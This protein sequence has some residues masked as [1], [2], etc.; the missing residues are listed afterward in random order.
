MI[1]EI[2]IWPDHRLNE[3]SVPIPFQELVD[4]PQS[5]A[6]LTQLIQDM[7]DTMYDTG[8][9]GLAAIQIGV[10]LRVVIMDTKKPV[11]LINPVIEACFG[12]KVMKNEGCLSLPGIIERVERYE[13]IS[14]SFYD[15]DGVKH[16]SKLSGLNA[17]CIQHEV[18]H[19]DG[20]VIPDKLDPQV[21]AQMVQRFAQLRAKKE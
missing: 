11:T 21:K 2:V 13:T 14:V 7:Y 5:K 3:K 12:N 4:D 18:D 17:Q 9:V 10:G 20:I 6:E 16:E 8:G 19:L 15:V 1:R